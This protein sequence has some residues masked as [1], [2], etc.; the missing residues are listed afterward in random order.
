VNNI[1]LMHAGRSFAEG[2]LFVFCRIDA[3]SRSALS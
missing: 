1:G 2:I 3:A